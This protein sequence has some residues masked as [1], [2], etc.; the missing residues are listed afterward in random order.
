MAKYSGKPIIKY[1]VFID[2]RRTD[3]YDKLQDAVFD[4]DNSSCDEDAIYREVNG[5]LGKC[6]RRKREPVSYGLKYGADGW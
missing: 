6:L 4:C 5:V 3:S 2:G 1:V